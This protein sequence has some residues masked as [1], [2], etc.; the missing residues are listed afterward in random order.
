MHGFTGNTSEYSED[1]LVVRNI[2][3]AYQEHE[4]FNVYV[5]GGDLSADSADGA[6]YHMW[7]DGDS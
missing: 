1:P 5:D 6:L 3:G 4:R 7:E 2:Y